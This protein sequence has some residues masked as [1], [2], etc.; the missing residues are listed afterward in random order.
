MSRTSYITPVFIR[1][2][3]SL[4][5]SVSYHQSNAVYIKAPHGIF[6]L[7][8]QRAILA[9]VWFSGTV[10]SHSHTGLSHLP[11]FLDHSS[12]DRGS[13]LALGAWIPA[14]LLQSKGDWI[15]DG[16]SRRWLIRVWNRFHY[17]CPVSYI[18]TH[19]GLKQ[20]NT[21]VTLQNVKNHC[22]KH[23]IQVDIA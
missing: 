5:C 11:S 14:G 21:L 3:G 4:K 8:S 12:D 20:T 16:T 7:S 2:V 17:P 10:L 1:L 13:A 9:Q 15:I 22:C 18:L 23:D 6:T 19:T